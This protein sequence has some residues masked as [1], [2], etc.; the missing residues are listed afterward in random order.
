MLG[1]IQ[2]AEDALQEAIA[3]RVARAGWLRGPQLAAGLALPDRHKRM[4][5]ADRPPPAPN[6]L[7]GPRPT[8][9]QTSDLGEPVSGPVWLEPWP[10]DDRPDERGRRR[11]GSP[12]ARYLRRERVELAFIAALQHLPGTQRAVL[13]LREVLEFS[14]AE[15]A[16]ILDTSPHRS[17]ARCNA[18]GRRCENACPRRR[19]RPSSPRSD[20]LASAS[21]STRSSRHGS[22][23]TSTSW[24]RSSPRTPSS[25]C[26]R[27]RPGS[28]G[29]RTSH[30]SSPSGCSRRRGGWCRC[31]PTARSVS[32]ATS[33]E[34]G[35]PRF[36]LGAVNV[37]S[38]RDGRVRAIA[39]FLDPAVHRAF[40]VPTELPGESR[41]ADR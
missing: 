30:G 6:P 31:E 15:T 26:R 19:S 7:A 32:P 22:G 21:S 34:P 38:L 3:R 12:A 37:L 27:C 28:T 10:D 36:G 39:G 40:G 23:P 5:P 33:V 17:T 14:A 4:P 41:R 20:R 8:A 16:A 25:P 11:S 13:L 9:D 1:S 24:S 29:A 35:E 2:D 18:P